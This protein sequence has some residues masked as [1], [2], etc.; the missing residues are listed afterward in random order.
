MSMTKKI[1]LHGKYGEGKFALVSDED[2]DEL[3]K[4]RWRV[5][6][7][8]YAMRAKWNP[9]KQNNDCILMHR[10]V[11][12]QP[13]GMLVD[14]RD[15]DKL[16]NTRG[17]LRLATKSQN[18]ANSPRRTNSNSPYKGV[19][20][21]NGKWRASIMK[22]YEAVYIGCYTT[23]EDAARAYDERAIELFGEYALLNNPEEVSYGPH[24]EL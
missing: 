10:E 24:I 16:N 7:H 9:K 4:Y 19:N 14:H 15:M 8:G 18:M 21:K 22:E 17:N 6:T 23:P 13:E 3:A 2:Y 20:F 1:P 5:G 11:M 12:E